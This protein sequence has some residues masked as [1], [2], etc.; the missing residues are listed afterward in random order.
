MNIT[1]LLQGVGSIGLFS[2]RV[3]LPAFLTALL[4]RF[5]HDIPLLGHTGLLAHT[6]GATPTWFTNNITLVI[7]GALSIV[8]V[9]GQKNPEVRR[10]LHEFDVH[11]KTA[12]AALT[13]LGVISSTDADFVRHTANQANVLTYLVPLLA[14]IGTYRVSTVRR[15]VMTTLFDHLD[16][17]HLDH[18]I[19][20]TED[21]W[22][23]FGTLLLILFPILMLIMVGIATGVLFLVRKRMAALEEQAKVP[24]IRC[25]TAI[26][27]CATACPSCRQGVA[28]PFEVGFL[29]LSKPYPS[30][31]PANHPYRLI[32]KRRCP[33][34]AT[35]LRQR[36]PVQTCTV[37]GND[38]AVAE[39]GFVDAYEN[40]IA[41]RLPVVLGVSFLLSLVPVIGLIV[42]T[43]YYRVELVTPFNQYLPL[44]RRFMLRWGIWLLFI[45]LALFQVVPLLGGFVVPVMAFISFAAYRSSFQSL[46]RASRER[47]FQGGPPAIVPDAR[48]PLTGAGGGVG[49][50]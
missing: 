38:L 22:A 25:G 19:S 36:M 15:Q 40:Y 10:L 21:A 42:G 49:A 13:S 47:V 2:S 41:R 34:C 16:G 45:I 24:C 48:A 33:V 6:H 39:P 5:G 50:G 20:W 43:I 35:G 46:V 4:I 32:E 3:F 18:L 7:L 17:T 23:L 14:A 8:E 28:Q 1:S 9:L 44:G 11:L 29:G 30:P 26:Y 37:C 12:L 31:D 27:P